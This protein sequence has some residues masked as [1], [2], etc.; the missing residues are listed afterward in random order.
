VKEGIHP[1]AL[2]DL[3]AEGL[4][5]SVFL[6]WAACRHDGSYDAFFVPKQSLRGIAL[7]AIG[8]PEPDASEYVRFAN[9]PGQGKLRNELI[10]QLVAHCRQNL[11]QEAVPR[12]LKLVDTLT[13]IPDGDVD[14]RTL[15]AFSRML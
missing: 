15:L 2:I 12:D 14:S 4:G 8:W 5:F 13:R 3:E 6:S 9:A 10:A 7:P 11:P 1:Q